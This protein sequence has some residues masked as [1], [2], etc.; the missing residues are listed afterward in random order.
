MSAPLAEHRSFRIGLFKTSPGDISHTGITRSGFDTG[1]MGRSWHSADY[2]RLREALSKA[3]KN[4]G[5]TQNVL[6]ERL[7]KPQSFVS[8]YENGERR[9]DV[10]E[11]LSICEALELDPGKEIEAFRNKAES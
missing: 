7:D 5:L 11:F 6:A 9:L 8:K 1:C 10:V 2:E 4:K 3:R